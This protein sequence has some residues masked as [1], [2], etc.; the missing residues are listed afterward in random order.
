MSKKYVH[1][2]NLGYGGS[3]MLWGSRKIYSKNA[4]VQGGGG[5]SASSDTPGRGG[6]GGQKRANFGGRPLWMA[7]NEPVNQPLP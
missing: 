1:C 2:A 3:L 5:G 6:R 4:D 7:P